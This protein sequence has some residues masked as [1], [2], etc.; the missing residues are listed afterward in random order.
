MEA[1]AEGALPEE[2]LA[3]RYGW[4]AGIVSAAVA[5]ASTEREI[6]LAAVLGMAECIR[7]EQ[8]RLFLVRWCVRALR[9]NGCIRS[10]LSTAYRRGF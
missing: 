4:S 6:R 10:D 9:G 3:K 8:L 1:E 7:E 5:A 2:A